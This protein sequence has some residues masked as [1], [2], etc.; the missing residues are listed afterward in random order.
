M[1]GN[2]SSVKGLEKKRRHLASLSFREGPHWA[3]NVGA[4]EL[5]T[6]L[7]IS[8]FHWEKH[9]G[10]SGAIWVMIYCLCIIMIKV[11]LVQYYE[12]STAE[13]SKSVGKAM[14]TA[15]LAGYFLDL[16][17]LRFPS[18]YKVA[19]WLMSITGA[20]LCGFGGYLTE[21]IEKRHKAH[22]REVVR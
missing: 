13:R 7:F 3:L 4:W 17:A 10:M 16:L 8:F 19:I 11:G 20:L 21:W 1:T 6:V 9:E 5:I 22:D 15:L 12:R 18:I 2:Q 14:L